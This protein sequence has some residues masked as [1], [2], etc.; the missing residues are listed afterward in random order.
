M[1]P[2]ILKEFNSEGFIVGPNESPADFKSRVGLLC[3]NEL[4][5]KVFGDDEIIT[6]PISSPLFDFSAHWIKVVKKNSLFDLFEPARTWIYSYEG[7]NVPI[8][9]IPKKNK[10]INLEEIL[11]HE[12]VHSM[13]SAF[14]TSKFEEFFAYMTSLSPLRKIF[15]PLF[16]NAIE[17][18]S[19]LA[20]SFL[21][22]LSIVWFLD[23][24]LMS[25]IPFISYF[26]FLTVRLILRRKTLV[27]C[28]LN[29]KKVFNKTGFI[30]AIA[31]RLTDKEIFLFSKLSPQNIA[32]YI[33]QQKSLRWQQILASYPLRSA[34]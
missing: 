8:I 33:S 20:L 7:R 2:K 27:K 34:V 5:E 12:A 32:V 10:K 25:F 6:Y 19:L 17:P 26:L 21:P 3:S 14:P 16:Q 11:Q 15:G 22:F 1:D 29:L 4:S 28:L 31:L 24:Y 30:E 9:Q 18:L 13:R 23:I